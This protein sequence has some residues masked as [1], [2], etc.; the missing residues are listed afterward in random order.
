MTCYFPQAG[1]RS[2]VRNPETGKYL[3]TFNPMKALNSTNPINI[4]CGKCIGCKL[5]QSQDWAVRCT[6][7]AQMHKQNC[8]ITLT[9]DNEHLPEDYSVHVRTWQLFCKKLR[10]HSQQKI[11]F[12]ACGEYGDLNLRPHYHALIFNLDF[13]DKIYFKKTQSGEILYTSQILTNLWGYGHCTTGNVTYA[14][15]GYCTRYCTKKITGAPAPD[16]YWRENPFTKQMVRVQ[17]E[18]A[19]QSRGSG[20][21]SAWFERYKSDVFPADF[22][23]IEGRQVKVPRF[24]EKKLQEEALAELKRKRKR[25]GLRFKKDK[26][27]ARLDVRHTVKLA[28]AK[29]LKRTL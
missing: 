16:H 27:R 21:G 19:T 4:P 24:Y 18:F 28:Q 22:I 13:P 17:P 8:F 14:S 10:K 23:V 29:Q 26:T 7:E 5:D 9:F 12:F 11:R 3:I 15:A 6:H 20:L 1:Y 2:Q 25:N